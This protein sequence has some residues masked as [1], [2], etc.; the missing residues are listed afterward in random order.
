MEK[1][2]IRK[3]LYS[4]KYGSL[5]R[6][7]VS[8]FKILSSAHQFEGRERNYGLPLTCGPPLLLTKSFYTPF[9]DIVEV[10]C[11]TEVELRHRYGDIR[12][13]DY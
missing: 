2:Y 3:S 1:A 5:K 4:N 10:N 11:V 9:N 6:L 7:Y 8:I 12:Y 13:G